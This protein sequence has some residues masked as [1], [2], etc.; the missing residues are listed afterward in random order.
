[1]PVS[2]SRIRNRSRAFREV[3]GSGLLL[4]LSQTPGKLARDQSVF[5]DTGLPA[6]SSKEARQKDPDALTYFIL[7]RATRMTIAKSAEHETTVAET[8]IS[9]RSL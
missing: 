3:K 2:S 6:S 5:F 1:M 4:N 8:V 9:S 7:K